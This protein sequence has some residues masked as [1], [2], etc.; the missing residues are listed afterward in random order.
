MT[1]VTVFIYSNY[2]VNY[3]AFERITIELDPRICNKYS[4]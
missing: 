1:A 4:K 2:V 3:K